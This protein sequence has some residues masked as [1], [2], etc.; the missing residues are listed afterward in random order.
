MSTDTDSHVSD[1]R[2]ITVRRLHAWEWSK[3][4]AIRLR[5]LEVDPI[6]FGSTLARELAYDDN[7]W[8]A[9][10]EKYANSSTGGVWVAVSGGRFIG[11]AGILFE[12]PFFHMWG[13]WMEPAFR[14]RHIA[15]RLVDD[16]ISWV[17]ANDKP[18][19][20]LLGVNPIQSSA[21][22]LYRGRGF[23]PTGTVEDLSHSPGQKIMEMRLRLVL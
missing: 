8:I 7:L 12:D 17:K 4:R 9:R 16:A 13:V 2:K 18:A 6:A 20:I 22:E 1:S 19:D 15:S 21:V 23:V 14:G 3:L 11:M 10:A 5:A